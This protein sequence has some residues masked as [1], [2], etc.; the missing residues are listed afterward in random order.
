MTAGTRRIRSLLLVVG[1]VGAPAPVVAATIDE[2]PDIVLILADDIGV[3]TVGAYGGQSFRTPALDRLA[4]EGVRF[5]NMHSLPLCTPSRVALMTGKYSFRN[6]RGFMDLD[7]AETTF[8]Q[9]LQRAGYRTVVAGKWQLFD[10][11]LEARTGSLPGQAGFA[12][13]QLWQL[14]REN[15]G[16]RYWAPTIVTNGVRR[17]YSNTVFGPDVFNDY[18]LAQLALTARDPLLIYY[19]MVLAHEP[20]VTTPDAP[21]AT[22]DQNRFGAMIAYMD[23]LV[24]D[25]RNRLV[26]RQSIRP[27][28]LIF[29][30]DNG[31]P[32]DL[33]ALRN[34]V[35][36]SGGKG[37]TTDAGTHTPFIAW[38]PGV[39]PAGQVQVG[40]TDF[41]DVLPTLLAVAQAEA[42]A[43]L[44][45]DGHNL[46][47]VMMGKQ[48]PTKSEIFIHYEPRW[49][50]AVPAR[51]VFD[52][53]YKLYED[54][55]FYHLAVDPLEAHALP[56]ARLSDGARAVYRRL[57]ARLASMPGGPL[58]STPWKPPPG[59]QPSA[60]ADR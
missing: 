37:L 21:A 44:V 24:G 48:Q 25:L 12:D 46:L 9:L 58:P 53:E 11:G 27:T 22:S 60:S 26:E 41:T 6:Y 35:R 54:G 3:E 28:L 17:V 36:V 45:L 56:T 20:L 18:V 33:H 50:N 49:F 43:D 14:R 19:P 13:Y 55:R 32:R 10:N 5:D 38:W 40:L 59:A 52:T 8:A 39:I 51:Y 1:L 47:P 57:A 31:T 42:P 16:S 2:R 34:G 4:A 29:I 15:A 30:S 7:P 23:K